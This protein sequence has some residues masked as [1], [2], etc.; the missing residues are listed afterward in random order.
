MNWKIKRCVVIPSL[1][2]VCFGKRRRRNDLWPRR[3]Q[4]R[5]V[6]YRQL[7][8]M[9]CQPEKGKEKCEKCRWR[10][11]QL[12]AFC[13]VLTVSAC[14]SPSIKCDVMFLFLL[15][16][17][18]VE[19]VQNHQIITR[20]EDG[21]IVIIDA[22]ESMV[23]TV[24]YSSISTTSKS[25][26]PQR[27]KNG[28]RDTNGVSVLR[29]AARPILVSLLTHRTLWFKS[30]TWQEVNVHINITVSFVNLI[31]YILQYVWPTTALY[32]NLWK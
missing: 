10:K 20:R 32:H 5:G 19:I 4:A 15:C 11:H 21:S 24:W 25:P 22:T 1:L 6:N 8:M 27:R 14:S 2:L 12:S 16:D 31:S 28:G 9:W 26:L 17:S 13:R 30:S 29:T 3:K 23:N 18:V 7:G